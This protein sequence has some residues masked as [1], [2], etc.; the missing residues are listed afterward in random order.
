[1]TALAGH[2][3]T[4]NGRTFPLDLRIA[5]HRGVAEVRA[6]PRALRA[7]FAILL[8]LLGLA[9][10]AA[11]I[12]LPPGWE[13]FGTSPSFEWGLLIVGYV[14]FA[15]MTS[16]LCLASS[17]GTVFGI[18][19]FRPLEKRHAVLAVLCLVSAFGIIALDLH[20]P[21][22]MVLG[23]VLSPAPSSAMWWMGVVYGAYLCILLVEVWSMFWDHPVIHQWACTFATCAAI[24]APS[25][26]GAVFGVLAARPFWHGP[27]TPVLMVASAFLAGTSLLSIVFSLVGHLRL[28]GFERARRLAIPSLRL[29]LGIGLVAVS[30]L[31]GRQMI[32]GLVGDE[33]GLRAATEAVL[34]GPLAV[35]FWGVRVGLGLALPLVLIVAPRWRTDRGLFVAA[36]CALGGVFV[37]RLLLV[38]GGEIAPITSAAGV[39]S[40]PYAAYTPSPVEIAIVVGAAAFVAFAY[41]LAERYLDLGESDVHAGF[42]VI[43]LLRRVQR[44]FVPVITFRSGLGDGPLSAGADTEVTGAPESGNEPREPVGPVPGGG[45]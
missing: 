7:W 1:M 2:T 19:R 14:F 33:R 25:T 30:V 5:A 21:V 34:A 29:L 4:V 35:P 18:D 45:R 43:Q 41:T 16:G 37:D 10:V 8:V 39:V 42:P 38:T 11:L 31:V 40:S 12:A 3:L 17:L 15:I 44:L 32:A 23:A 13:V 27:F 20:Y 9:A 6:M 28:A 26:L 24:A 36:V 22:R